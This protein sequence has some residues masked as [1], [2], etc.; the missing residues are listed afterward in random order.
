[1]VPPRGL[2]ERSVAEAKAYRLQ[3]FPMLVEGRGK[4]C[5]RFDGRR[6]LHPTA[7][8]VDVRIF[9]GLGGFVPRNG[10][11]AVSLG[12]WVRCR[13]WIESS[14]AFASSPPPALAH[15]ALLVFG[16]DWASPAISFLPK[17]SAAV[18][19]FAR[20]RLVD[21]ATGCKVEPFNTQGDG[22]RRWGARREEAGPWRC[23]LR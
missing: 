10:T 1:M 7:A 14:G 13:C 19:P 3:Y 21:R 16:A 4:I 5:P 2:L 17:L 15:A 12:G 22:K 18:H 8:E 20:S 6:V 9:D 23:C 11:R